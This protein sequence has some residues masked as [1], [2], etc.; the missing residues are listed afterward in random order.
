[1]A[2]SFLYVPLL[3]HTFHTTE[4]AIWLTLTSMVAWITMFDVGL[5]NG[6]RNKLSEAL[7][8]GNQLLGRELIST[9]YI[10]IFTFVIFISLIFAGIYKFIP[11][12]EVL[13]AS[14]VEIAQLDTL[15][16]IVFLAFCFQFALGLINSILFAL[17][18]PAF[19]SGLLMT[20]QLLSY[21]SVLVLS[22]MFKI[23]SL[24]VLGTIISIIPVA[25][26]FIGSIIV[27]SFRYR[28]L[29]PSL[30]LY[31]K[32]HVVSIFSIGL[33]F[34]F[35]Q[36][37]TLVL[38]QTNNLIITHVVDNAAV[39][40]YNV[41]YKYMHILP[42]LFTIIVTPIWSA[43]TEAYALGDLSWIR[44]INVKLLKIGFLFT[45][46]GCLM[47]ALS[48]VAYKLWLGNNNLDIDIWTTALLL[49]QSA[50]FIFYQIYGYMLNGIGKLRAQMLF[51]SILALVYIPLAIFLGKAFGL[52]GI[53]GAFA[54]NAVL[55]LLWS[56][57]Q[58]NKILNNT[59]K[60]IWAA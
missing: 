6:L 7:A 1:M 54:G 57:V 49:L 36:I 26:L 21:L 43:T 45:I 15:V 34:F 52:Y 16:L 59:A 53:L 12:S 30:K 18:L 27:F 2:I 14:E 5:G 29:R 33:K 32:V 11:W 28:E 40:D 24:L 44:N 31:N 60:G 38:Y 37:I 39:V 17:Q 22:K 25:V 47:L 8:K 50:F 19:S 55:N 13:N 3:L 4:Y 58:F 46:G 9:A 41:A 35:L 42:M 51:T 10:C 48:P 23:D 20:G 56:R